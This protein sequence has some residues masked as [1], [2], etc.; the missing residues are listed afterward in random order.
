MSCKVRDAI[1]LGT[2]GRPEHMNEFTW[3]MGREV[4]EAF[5]RC[6]VDDAVRAIVVTGAGR[7]FCA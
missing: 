4:D 2:L 7:A 3:R 6:D 1:A 5:R